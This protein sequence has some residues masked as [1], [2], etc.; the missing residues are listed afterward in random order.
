M[1]PVSIVML[2]NASLGIARSLAHTVKELYELAEAYETAALGIRTVAT[3][4]N[5]FRIAIQRISNWLTTQDETSRHNLDDDFW[6]A[7]ADNL[8]TGRL[9]LD[10]LEK[11][12]KGLKKDSAKFWTRTKYLW[13][14]VVIGELQSQIQGLM[15]AVS[16]LVQVIDMWVSQKFTEEPNANKFRPTTGGKR[17]QSLAQRSRLNNITKSVRQTVDQRRERIQRTEEQNLLDDVENESTS[18]TL[19]Q[20][21]PPSAPTPTAQRLASEASVPSRSN[22]ANDQLQQFSDLSKTES[23]P[24]PYEYYNDDPKGTRSK[25]IPL[26]SDMKKSPE[27]A[28]AEKQST[29]R[30]LDQPDVKEEKNK[31]SK[32]NLGFMKRSSTPKVEQVARSS[33]NPPDSSSICV[34]QPSTTSESLNPFDDSNS[35]LHHTPAPID[36]SKETDEYFGLQMAMMGMSMPT[37]VAEL[38]SDHIDKNI[39]QRETTGGLTKIPSVVTPPA[40]GYIKAPE[41]SGYS[42]LTSSLTDN[43]HFENT[44]TTPSYYPPPFEPP[45]TKSPPTYT[46]TKSQPS[47]FERIRPSQR[48]REARERSRSQEP[49][50]ARQPSNTS[51]PRASTPSLPTTTTP[52][53]SAP[54]TQTWRTPSTT[55][56]TS[57]TSSLSTSS[58][59]RLKITYNPTLYTSRISLPASHALHLHDHALTNTIDGVPIALLTLLYV[60]SDGSTESV[61]VDEVEL[62]VMHEGESRGME[63]VFG[64]GQVHLGEVMEG[65]REGC[66]WWS[67]RGVPRG[68][69]RTGGVEGLRL[70]RRFELVRW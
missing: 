52:A 32:W 56:T 66:V 11:R 18:A 22:S 33:S 64:A 9:V 35:Q 63:I 55:T 37:P 13:N 44:L 70:F 8:E 36:T 51:T 38:P 17:S 46:S 68:L 67:E 10:D 2:T 6:Q 69:V 24:P 15:S 19:Q 48:V 39:K 31:R 25:S 42:N 57:S 12:I 34:A 50:H 54:T 61:M 4:C 47:A 53:T 28:S 49:P 60:V 3:Q 43:T 1:D 14:S 20:P 65:S 21:L 41:S 23:A 62:E 29:F 58:T 5:S 26:P 16:I 27:A 59:L 30:V 45:T 7:L 40:E